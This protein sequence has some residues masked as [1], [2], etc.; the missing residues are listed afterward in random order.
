MLTY[1]EALA[2]DGRCK[3]FDESADGYGRAEGCGV[4]VLKRL[5]EAERGGDTVLALIRGTA[6]R[7]DGE[8]A[9][10]TG[11]ARR[12]ATLLRWLRSPRFSG[13]RTASVTRFWSVR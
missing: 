12:S 8:S 10:V 4:I 3:T 1:M 9:R 7:Q 5:S 2:P 6:G 11:P 13:R